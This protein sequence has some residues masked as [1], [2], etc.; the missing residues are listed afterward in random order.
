MVTM[1]RSVRGMAMA[2][3]DAPRLHYF[4]KPDEA[5]T[6]PWLMACKAQGY[7]PNGCL[8]VGQLVW[9][10][11]GEGKDPCKG[12]AGPREVCGGRSA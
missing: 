4:D 7:V 9:G 6:D 11:V 3:Q 12:C 1:G 2:E 5:K 10:L 8:L